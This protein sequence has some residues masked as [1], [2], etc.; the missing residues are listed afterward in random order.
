LQTSSVGTFLLRAMLAK[1]LLTSQARSVREVSGLP[2][3]L[4]DYAFMLKAQLY[5][6]LLSNGFIRH[7]LIEKGLFYRKFIF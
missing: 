4:V 6:F 2:L 7:F 1:M 3:S 5:H